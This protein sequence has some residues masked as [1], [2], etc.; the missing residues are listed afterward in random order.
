MILWNTSNMTDLI[1]C[2]ILSS[3]SNICNSYS[4]GFAPGLGSTYTDVPPKLRCGMARGHIFSVGDGADYVGPC[5]NIAARL[6][7]L[8]PNVVAS[9]RGINMVGNPA[10]YFITKK[11]D[12]RGIGSNELIWVF[13]PTLDSLPA[14][15][16]KQFK[17]P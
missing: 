13:K 17:D 7:K 3:M 10:K 1:I 5:I 12:I 9:K 15:E 6:Q 14:D 4:S 16:S 8:L 11:V 2:N